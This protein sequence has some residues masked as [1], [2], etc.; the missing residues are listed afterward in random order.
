MLVFR[1]SQKGEKLGA[2]FCNTVIF[3]G[4]KPKG[5]VDDGYGNKGMK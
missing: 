3:E 1:D 4:E 5:E 2:L